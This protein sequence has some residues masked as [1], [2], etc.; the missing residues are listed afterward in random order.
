MMR[1]AY[2]FLI[3]GSVMAA[4]AD[5]MILSDGRVVKGLFLGFSDRKFEFKE[6]TSSVIA[7]YPVN[8]KSITPD[9]PLKVSVELARNNYEDVEFRSFDEFTI[10]L[11]KDDEAI[12]ERVIMLKKLT[13]NRPPPEPVKPPPPAPEEL[14]AGEGAKKGAAHSSDEARDWKRS[15]KWKEMESKNTAIISRGEEV[16]VEDHLKKGYVNII[17][18]HYPKALASIREGNYI[19]ALASKASNRMVILKVLAPDFK[20]PICEALDIK[21]LPQFWFYDAQGRLVKKLTDRFTEGDIDAAL[22]LAR[23]GSG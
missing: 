9:A 3:L 23:R 11:T 21:S 15:G 22:K 7:E 17:H 19:E 16:D 20:A 12:D 6:S 8:V 14:S 2:F 10:R 5:T 1:M 13:V 18:F 4:Q